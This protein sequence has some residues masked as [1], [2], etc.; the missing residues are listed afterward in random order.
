MPYQPGKNNIFGFVTIC[1]GVLSLWLL[2]ITAGGNNMVTLTSTQPSPT[3]NH[4]QPKHQ[5]KFRIDLWKICQIQ[6]SRRNGLPRFA[7]CRAFD[8]SVPSWSMLQVCR[9]SCVIAL[10]ITFL[11]IILNTGHLINHKLSLWFAF[12]FYACAF[13][14]QAISTLLWV[15][16]ARPF[17]VEWIGGNSTHGWTFYVSVAA[18]TSLVMTA[19]FS[20]LAQTRICRRRSSRFRSVKSRA[21]LTDFQK[22]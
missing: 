8:D 7:S 20:A 5:T 12:S 1:F 6:R 13:T 2:L 4:T 14:F 9:I 11:G 19:L 10:S 3:I 17:L 15:K 21:L 16:N 18:V 22:N